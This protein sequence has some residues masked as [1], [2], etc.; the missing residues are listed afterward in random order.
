MRLPVIALAA[1][2]ALGTDASQFASGVRAAEDRSAT[3]RQLEAIEQA[4]KNAEQRAEELA[5]Q[6][7][8]AAAEIARLQAEMVASA[9]R[10]QG[11]E[12]SL[13][14]LEAELARLEKSEAS[15]RADLASE[16]ERL[17]ETL[18]ALQRLAVQPRE[19]M[20]LRPDAPIDTVRSAMLL[21]VAVPALDEHAGALKQQLDHLRDLRI[22][23]AR[24]RA[25]QEKGVASLRSENEQLAALLDQM[26]ALQQETESER[27]RT[28]KRL[29]ELAEQ[30]KDLRELLQELEKE[31]QEIAALTPPTIKPEVRS[32]VTSPRV[33]PKDGKGIVTPARGVLTEHYGTVG[34]AGFKSRGITLE[35][36]GGANVV[37]PFDGQVMF[38]GP[39]RGYGEILIIEHRGGYHTVLAGLGRT[40]A[41]VGQWLLAGEPVGIMGPSD[42]GNPRLYIELRRGTGVTTTTIDPAPW[43]GLRDK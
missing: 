34:E 20:I 6:A 22:E 3:E 12:A 8:D 28:A 37:A 27:A 23:I 24:R 32:D 15:T 29:E 7:D 40:D 2:L 41:T 14:E 26:K 36:R 17:V 1:F 38:R 4:R 43:L 9:E 35:T 25:E 10:A 18:A 30:A 39:F 21:K 11:S 42:S 13:S 19:A 33:F 5:R 16:R 31:R